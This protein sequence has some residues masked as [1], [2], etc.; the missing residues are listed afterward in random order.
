M[1]IDF[2]AWRKKTY[3]NVSLEMVG[4]HIM[5]VYFDKPPVNVGDWDTVIS[6]D[7]IY[8]GIR[9]DDDIRCIINSGKD[10]PYKGK[11]YFCA[12]ADIKQ[13]SGRDKDMPGI[14]RP[15]VR[16]M[17]FPR[18]NFECE[19]GFLASKPFISMVN[20]TAVGFGADWILISDIA[21]A[22][23]DAR[24][25]W[26]YIRVGIPPYEGGTWLLPRRVSVNIAMELLTTGRIIDADEALR[27]GIFNKVV[28]HNQLRDATLELATWY[29]EKGPPLAI[30]A[31]RSLIWQ[32][33][34]QGFHQHL[35]AVE[36]A[37]GC[38]GPDRREA[39][40]AWVEKREPHYEYK[41][42]PG[43]GG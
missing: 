29:A 38:V 6:F 23:E 13:W 27:L 9:E 5:I 7:E 28:P 17:I 40:A 12:G 16:P 37:E 2:K 39:M 30:G 31:T 8:R 1:G 43:R 33:L 34:T 25:G 18:H 3:K 24:I 10:T 36:L 32:G 11:H 14:P 21:I 20:G 35:Q 4:D 41:G 15:P 42:A 22:S 26:T 19:A